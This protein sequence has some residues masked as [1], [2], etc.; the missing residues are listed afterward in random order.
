MK[1][2]LKIIDDEPPRLNTDDGWDKHFAQFIDLC[3]NKEPEMRKSPAD[4]LKICKKF[5]SKAKGPEY[6]K[7]KLLLSIRKKSEDS[8]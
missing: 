4:L 6:I 3:L 7:S 5:F 8:S 2:I 1:V